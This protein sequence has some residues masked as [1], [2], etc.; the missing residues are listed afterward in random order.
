LPGRLDARNA[1]VVGAGSAIGG[2]CAIAFAREGASVVVVD[3]LEELA[4]EVASEIEAGGG[5]ALPLQASLTSEAAAATVAETCAAR[6]DRID[7]L[8][9]CGAAMDFWEPGTD[10]MADWEEIVRANVLGPLTYTKALLPLLRK[11]GS[12]SVVY[13][14]SIDGLR[15][16]P[17]FPAYSVTKGGL[18]PLTHVMAWDGA[19][20]GVRVNC[21]ATA[22]I[23]Q[24]SSDAKPPR[25]PHGRGGPHVEQLLSATPARR[26]ATPADVASVALFL[27]SSESSY[28][29]G[30]ILPM[31]GGRIA[32]TP[33]TATIELP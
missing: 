23:D 19:S 12:A 1:V 17:Y 2:A 3:P 29:T 28:V 15:G 32:V 6:W 10:T 24:T 31:D 18:I 14:G 33:G 11:S 7:A 13:L 20:D 27:A 21:I 9:N 25:F 5:W 22:A 30:A 8:V 4:R 26:M 16:N